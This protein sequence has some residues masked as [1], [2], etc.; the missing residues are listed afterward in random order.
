MDMRNLTLDATKDEGP[1]MSNKPV[2]AGDYPAVIKAS[3]WRALRCP[4]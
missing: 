1:T 3:S 4:T 2:P